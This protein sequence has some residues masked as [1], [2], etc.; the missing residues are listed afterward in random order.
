MRGR[1]RAR[2]AVG[3]GAIGRGRGGPVCAPSLRPGSRA[4]GSI[5]GVL[6]RCLRYWVRLARRRVHAERGP[7]GFALPRA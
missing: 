5:D 4:A 2:G 3:V 7:G 6:Q 1:P